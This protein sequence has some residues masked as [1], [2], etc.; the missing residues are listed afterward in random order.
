MLHSYELSV[1][2]KNKD[3]AV[4]WY[5]FENIGESVSVMSGDG[6]FPVFSSKRLVTAQ[7]QSLQTVLCLRVHAGAVCLVI[8]WFF[9]RMLSA[10]TL[11][12]SPSIVDRERVNVHGKEWL[13]ASADCLATAQ[14][15]ILQRKWMAFAINVVLEC[16]C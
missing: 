5:K 14:Q 9:K 12:L 16:S 10:R 4:F 15:Q 3:S 1:V 2:G 13:H 6:L 7:Q 11:G 8:R